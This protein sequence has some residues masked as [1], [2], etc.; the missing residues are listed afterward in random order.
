[1]IERK[2]TSARMSK[3]VI[4]NATMLHGH[5]QIEGQRHDRRR[6]NEERQ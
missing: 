1:M 2:R 6:R 3:I 4:H 5:L